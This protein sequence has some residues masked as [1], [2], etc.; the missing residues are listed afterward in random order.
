MPVRLESIK[1][2]DGERQQ[3]AL[4][5]RRNVWKGLFIVIAFVLF[6]IILRWF[7]NSFVP[8]SQ[9]MSQLVT[10]D[11]LKHPELEKLVNQY[12]ATT[13]PKPSGQSDFNTADPKL[14]FEL[15]FERYTDNFQATVD[16]LRQ[17]AWSASAA[18]EVQRSLDESS[19]FYARQE[20]QAAKAGMANTIDLA[21]EVNDRQAAMTT[22]LLAKIESAFAAGSEQGVEQYI[23]ALS[24]VDPDHESI[25][26]L[27]QQLSVLPELIKLTA[28]IK[29]F[30]AEN[31]PSKELAALKDM[32]A[33]TTLNA[34][35]Q[36][37][38]QQ[39]N[40]ILSNRN[41]DQLLAKASQAIDARQVQTAEKYLLQT[42]KFGYKK[43]E[44]DLLHAKLVSLKKRVAIATHLKSA[45]KS[46]NKE[47]WRTAIKSYKA[48]LSID[49][50]H[51]QA[52]KGLQQS[53]TIFELLNKM[54]RLLEKPLRVADNEVQKYADSLL[55][56]SKPHLSESSK[57]LVINNELSNLVT[58]VK[59]KR[60]VRFL[61]DGKT[62]IRIQGVG[63]IQPTR[64]KTIQ[65][66]PGQYKVFAKCKQ[67]KEMINDITVPID[68]QSKTV[69]VGCGE[70]I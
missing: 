54:A 48:V 28:Q 26:S 25:A 33:L 67:R 20:Y 52:Q 16:E 53:S 51:Q 70:R 15:L 41:V 55:E 62:T 49:S 19:D 45:A 2:E 39:L 35:E 1:S 5:L 69:K 66:Y 65:L 44:Q 68:G 57:L 18:M 60:G 47:D 8:E 31:K 64:D 3:K 4:T 59:T 50:T 43:E 29:R 27:E 22:D 40:S 17:L 23:N 56:K 13:P 12:S 14:E 36:Q 11:L 10:S 9:T 58:K 61:S 6:A 37:R 24:D 34:H 21:Q 7:S 42:S 32:S 63:F 38:K 46:V 30:Q